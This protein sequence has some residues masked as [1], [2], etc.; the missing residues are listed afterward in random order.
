[1]LYFRPELQSASLTYADNFSFRMDNEKLS[2]I[3]KSTPYI[4]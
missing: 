2:R 1:M 4:F 3:E